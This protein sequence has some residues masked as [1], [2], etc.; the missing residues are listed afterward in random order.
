[1][2]TRASPKSRATVPTAPS[3]AQPRPPG[4]LGPTFLLQRLALLVVHTG[5]DA[6][7]ARH[8]SGQNLVAVYYPGPGDGAITTDEGGSKLASDHDKLLDDIETETLRAS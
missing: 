1:M 5:L 6:T 3:R 4:R 7:S 8:R 2:T